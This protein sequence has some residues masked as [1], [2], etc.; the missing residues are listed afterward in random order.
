VNSVSDHE[1]PDAQAIRQLEQLVKHL[2]EELAAFRRRAFHAEG[3]L[4]TYESSTST[5]DLFAEQRAARLER[6]NGE[7]RSRL[8]YATERTRGVLEQ[9]RFLRQQA[10]RPVSNS[11]SDR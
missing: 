2:G 5:G 6:E 10:T 7:L 1:L 4:R 3:K 11:G 9:V 8:A